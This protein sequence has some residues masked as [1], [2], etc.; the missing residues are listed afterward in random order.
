MRWRD[1]ALP[2]L[3]YLTAAA[4]PAH[5]ELRS[6]N[7]MP[8][9]LDQNSDSVTVA[10][11]SASTLRFQYFSGTWKLV[12]LPSGNVVTLVSPSSGLEIQFSDGTT[13]Q[14]AVLI[15]GSVSAFYYNADTGR[16]AIAPYDDVA[17]RPTGLRSH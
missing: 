17:H 10:N 2:L 14:S 7:Q 1:I 3:L 4:F 12:E 11:V 9:L 6:I 8:R 16:W 13:V 15:R 5:A